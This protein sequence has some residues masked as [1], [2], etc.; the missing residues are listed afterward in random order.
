MWP[1]WPPVQVLVNGGTAPTLGHLKR[2]LI[3]ALLSPETRDADGTSGGGNSSSGSS[4]GGGSGVGAR[5]LSNDQVRVFKYQPQALEW[6]ELLSASAASSSAAAAMIMAAGSSG[7]GGR[8]ALARR[9]KGN[10]PDNITQAPYFVKEGDQFCVFNITEIRSFKG[11]KHSSSGVS[12]GG[13][14]AKDAHL[15]GGSSSSGAMSVHASSVTGDLAMVPIR[16]ALSE[17][18]HL[19]TLRSAEKAQRRAHLR[20]GGGLHIYESGGFYS[21]GGGTGTGAGTGGG[22]NR[23]AEV[24]LSLGRGF[25]FSDD[26][27]DGD[28]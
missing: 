14:H 12:K 18:V 22:K 8:T 1:T 15:S 9:K 10:K 3:A 13:S 17:D 20:K 25:E 23:R 24:G 4:G 11:K 19:R 26:E 21:G 5:E 7:G 16:V 2:A 28:E 27:D 6:Q